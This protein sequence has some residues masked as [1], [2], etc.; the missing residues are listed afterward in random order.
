MILYSN[1]EDAGKFVSVATLKDA[2]GDWVR[3]VAWSPSIGAPY[4][5]LVSCSEVC[6]LDAFNNFS[7]MEASPFGRTQR[8]VKTISRKLIQRSVKDLHGDSVSLLVVIY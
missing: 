8:L 6:Q 5:T 2:H 4:E 7:R 3:D 1:Y